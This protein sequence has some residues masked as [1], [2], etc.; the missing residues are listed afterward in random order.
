MGLEMVERGGQKFGG[1]VRREGRWENKI[2]CIEMDFQSS[3]KPFK[4]VKKIRTS[5]L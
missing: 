5:T 2:N 3:K 1:M 4:Y